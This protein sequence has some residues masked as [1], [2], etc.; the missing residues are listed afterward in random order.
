MTCETM[1]ADSQQ[2]VLNPGAD[3]W[4]IQLIGR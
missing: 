1:N 2:V 3:E 4:Q